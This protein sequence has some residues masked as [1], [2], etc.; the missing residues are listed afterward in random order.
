MA[1]Q[2]QT[3]SACHGAL[4]DHA[5]PVSVRG[6]DRRVWPEGCRVG[7]NKNFTDKRPCATW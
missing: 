1:D 7:T 3:H 5:Q 6:A 4:S 2:M